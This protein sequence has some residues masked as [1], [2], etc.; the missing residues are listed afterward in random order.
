[1]EDIK[2]DR[3]ELSVDDVSQDSPIWRAAIT[4]LSRRTTALEAACRAILEAVDALRRRLL[5]TQS[6]QASLDD[7]LSSLARLAPGFGACANLTLFAERDRES[8]HLAKLLA[9]LQQH[10][11]SPAELVLDH[12]QRAQELQRTFDIESKDYYAYVQRWLAVPALSRSAPLSLKS[13][14]AASDGVQQRL[15]LGFAL[16]RLELFSSLWSLH[17]GEDELLLATH[18]LEY[19]SQ[20]VAG[21]QDT[22][23]ADNHAQRRNP[24][25]HLRDKINKRG[26]RTYPH[27]GPIDGPSSRSDAVPNTKSL[28]PPIAVVTSPAEE[29]AQTPRNQPI[30]SSLLPSSPPK[31]SVSANGGPMLPSQHSTMR[32]ARAG[33]T[34]VALGDSDINSNLSTIRDQGA[35]PLHKQP[36]QSERRKEG[37]LWIMSRNLQSPVGADAP[38]SANKAS[39]WQDSWVVLS[40]GQLGEYA[41]WR[42]AHSGA[43]TLSPNNTPIDLRFASVKDAKGMNRRWAFEV[44][45]RDSVRRFYQARSEKE[46]REWVAAINRAIESLLN[47]TGTVRQ[48][49]KVVAI[50]RE[51]D[52]AKSPTLPR[53]SADSN[54]STHLRGTSN[55]LLPLVDKTP[56]RSRKQSSL[57]AGS[58]V[59]EADSPWSH[60]PLISRNGRRSAGSGISN[61]TPVFDYVSAKNQPDASREKDSDMSDHQDS[62]NLSGIAFPRTS[63]GSTPP[64]PQRDLAGEIVEIARLPGNNQCFDCKESGP[65]WASWA[66]HGQLFVVFLCIRC[67]GLHRGLGVQISKVKSVTLDQWTPAQ[68]AAARRCGNH[69]GRLVWEAHR[70]TSD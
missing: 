54:G 64:S 9:D 26:E 3:T 58:P 38:K 68:V 5:S 27:S 44:V 13:E 65:Q 29:D 42:D 32:K 24:M 19:A 30:A 49:D 36:T 14:Q 7:A 70:P 47:G 6:A 66:L 20:A 53:A 11:K 10:V 69:Q 1:M 56:R 18:C 50:D 15:D 39:H 57:G 2:W 45:T 37:L 48:V 21:G 23:Q 12:C 40:N 60:L 41:D 34:S 22:L 33:H 46:M 4:S 62:S 63:L 59:A 55:A 67:S 8:T 28:H 17:G 31:R 43:M 25:R 16:L 51:L 52:H 61:V 35:P